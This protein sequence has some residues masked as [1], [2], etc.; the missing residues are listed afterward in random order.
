MMLF[1]NLPVTGPFS[2][3]WEDL[4]TNNHCCQHLSKGLVRINRSLLTS[5][6]KNSHKKGQIFNQLMI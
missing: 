2:K 6:E 1:I 4:I 5:D 3:K